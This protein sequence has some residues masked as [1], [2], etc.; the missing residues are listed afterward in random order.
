MMIYRDKKELRVALL[1]AFLGTAA[2]TLAM[3]VMHRALP[4]SQQ[5]PLPPYHISMNM[6]EWLGLRNWL[7][8][9]QR[10]ATTMLLHFGYG[11]IVGSLYAPFGHIIAGWSIFKGMVFGYWCGLGVTSVGY[12][13]QDYCPQQRSMRP[14]ATR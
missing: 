13:A 9:E 11:T 8:E 4:R 14:R 2:M 10:F 7:D 3:V 6:A 12:Q 1:S 5:K